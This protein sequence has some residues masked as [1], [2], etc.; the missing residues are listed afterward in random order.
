VP[1]AASVETMAVEEAHCRLSDKGRIQEIREAKDIRTWRYAR[2]V[3]N[4]SESSV[5]GSTLRVRSGPVRSQAG[6]SACACPAL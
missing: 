5:A 6:I 4:R 2:I 3:A 1:I